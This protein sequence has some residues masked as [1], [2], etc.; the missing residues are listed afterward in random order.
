M[1]GQND[2]NEDLETDV[3]NTPTTETP[4]GEP[5]GG[6]P[7]EAPRDNSAAVKAAG[8]ALAKISEGKVVEDESDDS[9]TQANEQGSQEGSPQEAGGDLS[10]ED[11]DLLAEADALLGTKTEKAEGEESGAEAKTEEKPKPKAEIKT[12]ET[13][14]ASAA[15]EPLAKELEDIHGG[16]AGK[17]VRGLASM[18]DALQTEIKQLRTVASAYEQ[19]QAQAQQAEINRYYDARASAG[20]KQYGNLAAGQITPE[21]VAVRNRITAVA[22][23]AFRKAAET[24]VPVTFEDAVA[25]AERLV[26]GKQSKSDAVRQVKSEIIENNKGRLSLRPSTSTVAE[27][28][29][30][31]SKE[32]AAAAA[33]AFLKNKKKSG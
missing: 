15:V 4:A 24:G 10:Q 9:S 33:A 30:G 26:F 11:K 13:G 27:K 31:P 8:D 19:Q 22:V 28:Q 29:S 6:E 25:S 1:S 20:V 16:E 5:A 14:S 12:A 7:A 32:S 23:T 17:A 3:T 21:N 18:V 2:T